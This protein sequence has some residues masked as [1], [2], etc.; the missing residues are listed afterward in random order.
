MG[1]FSL[2]KTVH[3]QLRLIPYKIYDMSDNKKHLFQKGQ[4]GNP[5]GRPKGSKN[6][7]SIELRKA[8]EELQAR[9]FVHIEGWL[10]D[11]AEEDKAKAVELY[12]KMTEYI[13]PKLARTE[14]VHEV[15]EDSVTGFQINI[16]R[17]EDSEDK[18]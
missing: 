16:V 10:Q 18:K 5:A 12:L 1:L 14:N 2:G 17:K 13:M 15:D 3:L 4:S 6:K 9:N 8:F 11:V 7:A